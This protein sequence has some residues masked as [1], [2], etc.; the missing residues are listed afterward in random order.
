[1]DLGQKYVIDNDGVDIIIKV[2]QFSIFLPWNDLSCLLRSVCTGLLLNLLTDQEQLYSKVLE[3]GTLDTLSSILEN[4]VQNKDSEQAAMHCMI[5]I[6]FL[7]EST[8]DDL[9]MTERLCKAVVKILEQSTLGEL[10][11]LCVELLH[12]QA[13]NDCVG[14]YLARAGLGELLMSLLDKHRP[15]VYDDELRNLMKMACDVLIHILN[16]D[17]AMLLL[18]ADGKGKVFQ[19][20]MEW[21]DSTDEYMMSTAILAMANFAH[22]DKHSIQLVKLG[23]AKKLLNIL[24]RN[25]TSEADIRLQHALLSGLRNL[26]I[27]SENKPV[28]LEEGLLDVILPMTN[29]PT[30]PVVFNLLPTLRIVINGQ[31]KPL[32]H[33]GSL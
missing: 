26:V 33:G 17:E 1:S 30:Y 14:L 29:I 3:L 20:M 6:N 25:N 31:G 16:G 24:S 10:S 15:A 7:T 2:L 11:E 28:V 12:S 5:I 13:A 18:F 19:G 9:L 8:P 32:S 27:P 21:L 4:G 22:N 23:V